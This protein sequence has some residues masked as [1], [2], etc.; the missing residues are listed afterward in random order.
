MTPLELSHSQRTG[1]DAELRLLDE[2][3]AEATA[4]VHVAATEALVARMAPLAAQVAAAG[5][6]RIAIYGSAAAGQAFV[7]VARGWDLDVRCFCETAPTTKSPLLG[8]PVRSLKEAIGADCRTF[9]I[10]SFASGPQMLAS[11]QAEW[12]PALG[13]YSVFVPDGPPP[14]VPDEGHAVSTLC[15]LRDAVREGR[16]L[17]DAAWL[18]ANRSERMDAC[19]A[20]F[21]PGRRAFHLA[22]YE[23]AARLVKGKHVLDCACGTGYGARV[24]AD[25]GGAASVTG[26]DL[27]PD[28]VAYAKRYYG[29]EPVAFAVSSAEHAASLDR[30]FDVV[31][32]FETLE[33]VAD[34][35]D[36][37]AQFASVLSPGGALV[38]STP[39]DWPLNA[40]HVRSYTE[41][42][43]RLLLDAWFDLV[44]L[45]AQWSSDNGPAG[46]ERADAAAARPAECFVAV[47]RRPRSPSAGR[48]STRT[49][50]HSQRD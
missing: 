47:C 32:S 42:S 19:L 43:L 50:R 49:G 12:E 13:T 2:C 46:L 16:L 8:L 3:V 26:I 25:E 45:F 11:L 23:F 31:V 4:A 6:S 44:E 34:D 41:A 29:A 39:N 36:L 15:A 21:A 7:T 37:L 1:R 14:L 22:R 10:G 28:T 20:L 18:H 30:T 27:D 5:A 17:S 24:L 35:G 48:R 40:H 38:V 9:V 33:H